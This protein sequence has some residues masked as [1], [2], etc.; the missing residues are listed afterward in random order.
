LGPDYVERYQW[1][2]VPTTGAYEVRDEDVRKGRSMTLT[3]VRDWWAKDNR[4]YRNRFNPD[5]IRLSVIRDTSKSFEVFMRGEIDILRLN[6]SDLW[7]EKLPDTHPNV[8]NG[9]IQKVTFYNDKPRATYGLWMNSTKGLLANRDVRVGIQ[10]ASNWGTVIDKFFR[11]D[12]ARMRTTA[13]GYGE[14]THPT[15]R[16]RAFDIQKAQESFV[17][18]GFVERGPDGVLVNENG[19]RLSFTLTTGYD[20]LADVLTILK[21]EALK[22]GLEFRV[23]VLDQTASFKKAQEKKHDVLLVAFNVGG[24]YPVYWETYHSVNAY[25]DAFLD[26]GSINPGRKPNTQTNNLEGVA[27]REL[28][29]MIERY[30]TVESEEDLISIAHRMEELLHDYASFVPG[31]IQGYERSAHWRWVRWPDDFNIR[32]AGYVYEYMVHW[33]D[34]DLRAETENAIRQEETFPP[35][36]TVYDQYKVD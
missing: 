35:S 14:V 3:R 12:Y 23:E 15:L 13:D 9:Y 8:R 18:A 33:I 29:E 27:I 10:F 4:Y 17:K 1:R 30:R 21:E 20:T 7:Y 22:A 11:G 31:F 32:D 5:K 6:T 28:D 19:E 24:R 16:A 25:D 36:I 34:E 2:F 26:D